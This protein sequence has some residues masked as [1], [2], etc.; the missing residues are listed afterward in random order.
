[1]SVTTIATHDST[2]ASFRY[3]GPAREINIQN[4]CGQ[5]GTNSRAGTPEC[6]NRSEWETKKCNAL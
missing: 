1:M 5:R 4:V 2:L 3:V 6:S